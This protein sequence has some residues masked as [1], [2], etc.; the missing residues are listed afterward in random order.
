MPPCTAL[1][2]IYSL[3]YLSHFQ[4]PSITEGP[5]F[6]FSCRFLPH[7]SEPHRGQSC[8]TDIPHC[9]YTSGFQILFVPVSIFKF[10]FPIAP[11]LEKLSLGPFRLKIHF[12]SA[13]A[14]WNLIW[15]SSVLCLCLRGHSLAEKVA[16][17]R[18][19]WG[20]TRITCKFPALS[21]DSKHAL[22]HSRPRA[23]MPEQTWRG[24]IREEVIVTQANCFPRCVYWPVT[25]L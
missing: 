1:C 7:Y 6:F 16:S 25:Q 4:N 24:Q 21:L 23:H 12:C 14:A 22:S 19:V 3:P 13:V 8:V 10:F 2:C 15:F 17:E 18:R 20:L 9:N 5:L 11:H